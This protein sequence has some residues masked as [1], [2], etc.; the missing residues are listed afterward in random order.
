MPVLQV[1]LEGYDQLLAQAGALLDPDDSV[2]SDQ[3]DVFSIGG[4]SWCACSD[5]VHRI[6]TS[7]LAGSV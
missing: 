2:E 5:F 3:S 7:T 4:Y 1:T 6:L